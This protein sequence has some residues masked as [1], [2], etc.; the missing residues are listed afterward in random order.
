MREI[1]IQKGE[2]TVINII[3]FEPESLISAV[4]YFWGIALVLSSI[5][6]KEARISKAFVYVYPVIEWESNI[7]SS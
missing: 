5:A 2:I 6:T 3:V 4:C 7:L 1:R